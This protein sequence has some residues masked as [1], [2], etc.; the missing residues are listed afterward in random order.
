MRFPL[1]YTANSLLLYAGTG[2]LKVD[3]MKTLLHS[4]GLSMSHRLVR[5][6]T[7]S[8][9]DSRRTDRIYYRELTEAEIVEDI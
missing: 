1:S 9:A 2:Y 3:D 5:E 6:L 8:V 7:S 4:L